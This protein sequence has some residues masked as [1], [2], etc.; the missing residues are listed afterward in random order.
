MPVTEA[1]TRPGS[2]ETA[3]RYRRLRI[4]NVVVGLVHGAQGVLMLVLSNDLAFPVTGSFLQDDPVAVGGPFTPERVFDLRIG[5]AVAVFL[6]LAAADHLLVAAPGLHRWYERKLDERANIA[7]WMEYSL[8]AS[9]MMVL[10]ALFTGIW[11]LAALLAIFAATAAMILFGL[12][13]E[14]QQTPGR[15][16]WSAFWF[17]S[18]VGAVPWVAVAVYLFN[19]ADPPGSCTRSSRSSSC[20]SSASP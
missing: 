14:R 9:L 2:Q 13:M 4:F 3:A 15:A 18:L 11:D 19:G 20:S 5:P 7:R 16:D 10:I 6:L 1:T 12:L 8:S 17:G